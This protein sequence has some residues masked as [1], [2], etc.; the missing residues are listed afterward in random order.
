[1]NAFTPGNYQQTRSWKEWQL[2]RY[3]GFFYN[4]AATT[5]AGLFDLSLFTKER[6][7]RQCVYAT[8]DAD[9]I[10]SNWQA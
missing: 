6:I 10:I 2:R 3:S 7:G 1:M 5:L 8:L 4:T 9:Q